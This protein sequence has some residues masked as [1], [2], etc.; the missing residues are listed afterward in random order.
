MIACERLWALNT[1]IEMDIYGLVVVKP[2]GRVLVGKSLLNA[3]K[4]KDSTVE[5]YKKI[6]GR[7]VKGYVW[8]TETVLL[9]IRRSSIL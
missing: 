2:Q 5:S 4:V 9:L 3:K 1:V 8:I 6:D 7:G